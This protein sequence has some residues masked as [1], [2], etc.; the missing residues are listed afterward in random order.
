MYNITSIHS[1]RLNKIRPILNLNLLDEFVWLA[2]GSLQTLVNKNTTVSDY[3]LFFKTPVVVE[4]VKNKLLNNGFDVIFECPLGELFSYKKDDV[5][6]QLITKF[7]Y[8][9]IETMLATFDF[10]CTMWGYDGKT[11]YTTR[12]AIKHSKNQTLSFNKITYPV[13]TLKRIFKYVNNK[14][15]TIDNDQLVSLVVNI[16]TMDIDEANLIFY[17]D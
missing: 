8:P 7:Y 6:I 12:D 9:D 10:Q 17:V 5:K 2:G 16:N 11:L 4:N 3:D 15:Y 1:N 14:D 13:A